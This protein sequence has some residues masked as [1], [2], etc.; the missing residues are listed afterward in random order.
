MERLYFS[1]SSRQKPHLHQLFG[2]HLFERVL[3]QAFS[4]LDDLLMSLV[5][6]DRQQEL[7]FWPSKLFCKKATQGCP[8]GYFSDPVMECRC[9]VYQIHRYR[10][11]VSGPLLDRIDI[12]MEVPRLRHDEIMR[13]RDGE[14]SQAIRERV[15]KARRRQQ[16]RFQG[17]GIH[18]NAQMQSRH[19]RKFCELSEDGKELLRTAI[20]QLNLSARAYDRI[21]KLARTIADLEGKDQIELHHLAEAIQYRSLDRRLWT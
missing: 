10:K 6:L 1:P 19:L 8:C 14:S 21:L 20:I 3:N 5:L 18:C 17:L 15:K 9:S 16:R 12:H 4:F 11:K 7:V 13:Q 2:Q